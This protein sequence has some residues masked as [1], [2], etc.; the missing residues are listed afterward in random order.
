MRSRISV[1]RIGN[2]T[3][4]DRITLT[5]LFL[6]ASGPNCERR[7]VRGAWQSWIV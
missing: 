1:R 7:G 4:F 5:N 2:D 3:K 6:N